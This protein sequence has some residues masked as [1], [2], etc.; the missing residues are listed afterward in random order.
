EAGAAPRDL[1]GDETGV[2]HR[3]PD[4]AVLDGDRGARQPELPR[5]TDDLPRELRGLI[6]VARDGRDL[7]ARE[8]ASGRLEGELLVGEAEVHG[9]RGPRA[10]T[11]PSGM[12]EAELPGELLGGADDERHDL[13][14][15]ALVGQPRARARDREAGGEL[16]M[17]VEDRSGGTAQPRLA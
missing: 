10:P 4:A 16:A 5:A 7:L 1:L 6:V 13:A 15:E 8:A 11:A 9:L 14:E 2:E 12:D 3:E 17:P